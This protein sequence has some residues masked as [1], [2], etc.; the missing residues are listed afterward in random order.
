MGY[1]ETGSKVISTNF[2]IWN[3]SLVIFTTKS[4]LCV[5]Y[6]KKSWPCSLFISRMFLI[7]FRQYFEGNEVSKLEWIGLE[8]WV[9]N[10]E[11]YNA[12][13]G[14]EDTRLEYVIESTSSSTSG[15]PFTNMD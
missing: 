6:T 3:I 10:V 4:L 15:A 13:T 7:I 11:R 5:Q 2:D 8:R 14:P 12:M 9:S 1:T